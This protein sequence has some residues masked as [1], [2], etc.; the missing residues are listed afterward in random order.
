MGETGLT[1]GDFSGAKDPVA[2]FGK[3]LAD[4]SDAEPNDPTAFALAT[5]DQDGLPDVRMIL[6]KG[7]DETGFVFYTNYESA[8]GMELLGSMKAAMC[9]HW[10]SLRRQVRL[11]GPVEKV[12]REEA[13][14]YFDTRPRGSRIG[15]WASKQS[16]PLESRFALEKAVA[17]YTA[18]FGIGKIPRPEYWSGFR[19]K[20]QQFEFW[21][22]RPFRLHDRLLFSADD[23][24]GWKTDRLYP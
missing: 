17:E 1:S 2:L 14:A 9:F 21:H 3:W 13:D 7:F 22:D 20:P 10:K 19:I 15:A 24:G 11:R 23:E 5:V 4:A 6:L 8:K 16:R 18:K 12:T